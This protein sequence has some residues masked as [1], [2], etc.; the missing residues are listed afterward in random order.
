MFHVFSNLCVIFQRI[1]GHT[2]E[3]VVPFVGGFSVHLP[4]ATRRTMEP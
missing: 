4:T 1:I 2:K 3:G